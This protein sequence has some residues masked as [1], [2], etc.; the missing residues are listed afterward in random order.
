MSYLTRQLMDVVNKLFHL[1][2]STPD[3]LNVL[4]QMEK[5]LSRVQPPPYQA[6]VKVLHPI[7]LALTAEKLVKHPDVN[8]NISV[9]CCI[10]EIIRI[11]VPNTPYNH[12]QMKV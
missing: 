12:E 6:M 2:S 4:M 11:M 3:I 9:V 10:C 7:I 8:V 5:V 1:S